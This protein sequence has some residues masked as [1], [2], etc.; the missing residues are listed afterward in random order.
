MEK[1]DEFDEWRAIRQ[2]LPFH[3][4]P[5]NTFP[6]KATINSS[7]F[8]SLKFLTCLIRQTFSPSKFCAIQYLVK[9]GNQPKKIHIDHLLPD[10]LPGN[11]LKGKC[12]TEDWDFNPGETPSTESSPRDVPSGAT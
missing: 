10:S 1:S 5:V 2:S 11:Y 7:K 6:M 9:T 3:S 12:T 4:F 8:Y